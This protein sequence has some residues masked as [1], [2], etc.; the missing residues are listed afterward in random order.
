MTGADPIHWSVIRGG[1]GRRDAM[2]RIAVA[3]RHAGT[4]RE[5]GLECAISGRAPAVSGHDPVPTLRPPSERGPDAGRSIMCSKHTLFKVYGCKQFNRSARNAPQ[6]GSS[7]RGGS[8][9][10]N[11]PEIIG[12][13]IGPGRQ[14]LS[15]AEM[16]D[17]VSPNGRSERTRARKTENRSDPA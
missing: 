13:E 15:K 16:L 12:E 14:R 7:P 10:A 3:S 2:Q 8:K 11:R 9:L 1:P 17:L 4:P 6:R 5:V